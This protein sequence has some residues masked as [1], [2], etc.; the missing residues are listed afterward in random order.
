MASPRIR[1]WNFDTEKGK[2]IIIFCPLCV[3][4]LQNLGGDFMFSQKP[5]S[6]I[7]KAKWGHHLQPVITFC[8]I[9]LW[10]PE[11]RSYQTSLL[12]SLLQAVIICFLTAVFIAWS[13]SLILYSTIS[14]RQRH[15]HANII[16]FLPNICR[17]AFF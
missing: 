14:I 3:I 2:W 10:L 6:T 13:R 1:W 9:V 11:K 5:E 16:Y 7:S 12:R 15:E 17:T 8:K 4:N